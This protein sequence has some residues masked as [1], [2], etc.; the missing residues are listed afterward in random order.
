MPTPPTLDLRLSDG[1]P[2]RLR[3]V[4]P[5]DRERVREGYKEMS[6]TSRH[7][8][9]F[10]VGDEMSETQA[11]YFTEI[12]QVDHVALCAVEPTDEERGYGIA[13]YVRDAN[14]PD[15]GEFAIA[16]IDWMQRR[17]L[18]TVLLAALYL[19]ARS[20]GIRLLRGDM[21]PSN[22]VMP[23]WFPQLNGRIV[24]T[25][26]PSSVT[27]EWPL[28]APIEPTTSAARRFMEWVEQLRGMGM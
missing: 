23:A 9:F 14:R 28:D 8:R 12:D 11:R 7:M 19:R 13:R 21:M 25:A 1:T 22:P 26:D 2:V 10:A 3:A 24:S 6:E 4:T 16:V 27:I 15:V 20:S 5:A 18:G 17:G